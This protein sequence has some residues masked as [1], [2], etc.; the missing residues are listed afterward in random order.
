MSAIV[1]KEKLL[2]S[3]DSSKNYPDN[4]EDDNCVPVTTELESKLL[5][6]FPDCNFIFNEDK[7]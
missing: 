1:H 2:M 5:K 7:T 6:T 3:F 4:W